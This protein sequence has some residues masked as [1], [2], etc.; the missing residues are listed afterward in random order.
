MGAGLK[1]IWEALALNKNRS[2]AVASFTR[3]RFFYHI[4]STRTH[5][6]VAAHSVMFDIITFKVS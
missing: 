4:T 6:F 3:W 1:G 2:L 5:I